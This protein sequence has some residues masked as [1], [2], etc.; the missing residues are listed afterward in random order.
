MNNKSFAVFQNYVK[1]KEKS[2]V[3]EIEMNQEVHYD[4][5]LNVDDF[6]HE[7]PKYQ[8]IFAKYKLASKFMDYN[9]N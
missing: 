2:R 3:L 1:K 8:L 4:F 7:I 6:L 5:R 9:V